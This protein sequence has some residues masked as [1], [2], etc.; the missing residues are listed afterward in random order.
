[1]KNNLSSLLLISALSLSCTA[2]LCPDGSCGPDPQDPSNNPSLL[3][4]DTVGDLVREAIFLTVENGWERVERW[5]DPNPGFLQEDYPPDGRGN[6][7]GQRLIFFDDPQPHSSRFLLYYAPGWDDASANPP[8]L[9][10]H[11]AND[12][13][14]RAWANPNGLGGFGCG[15]VFCP[16]SG[17]MQYLAVRGFRVFALGFPHKQGDNYYWAE[18][19]HDAIQI[20]KERTGAS[21]V[22]VIGWSKGVT[23]SRM[24]ASS[25]RKPW[26]TPYQGDIRRLILL[27][28][29]NGGFDYIFRYGW[30]HN[31]LIAPHCGGQ[32]N[33]PMP[34][35]DMVCLGFWRDYDEYS[36]YATSKGDFFPGQK[37]MLARW[38]HVYPVLPTSQDWFTTYYGG[39][40]FF[41]N[42]F[43]IDYAIAQGSLIQPIQQ[44]G[45]PASIET[46]LLCGTLATIPGIPNEISGPSDGVVFI[47]SCMDETGIG[48]NVENALIPA[49]HLELGWANVAMSQ[50]VDWLE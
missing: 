16:Q 21:K 15:A 41:T 1:M 7:E 32:V 45:I 18:Q 43:G 40:G 26:G 19:I 14:D 22:D 31:F 25:V 36:I 2:E 38:D 47:D 5:H 10:V 35:T 4:S 42:G 13:A 20:I 17:L 48:N 24:Y 8:V 49:N 3:G 39:L 44:A 23:A 50:I 34:H 9:L 12:T 37:Q 28:G 6:Q 27:G 29:P 33:A 30:N 11:G 46:Y